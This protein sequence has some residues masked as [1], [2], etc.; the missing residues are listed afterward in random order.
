M[1]NQVIVGALFQEGTSQVRPPYFNGQHFSHWKVRMEIYAKAYDVKVWRVIKKGN[2]PLP[3]AAQPLAD[4]EDIDSYT[5]KQIEVV[6]VTNKA[7][8]LLYNAISGEEYEKISS[9]DTAKEMWDKLE[10]TY[11]GISKVKETHINMLVHDYELF[12]MK[13]GDSI[14]EM[15]ARFSKIIKDLKAFDKPYTRGDQVRKKFRSLPTTWK[16]KIVTLESQD[17]NKL[18]YDELRGE[19]IAF[20]NTHL[21]KTNQEE[22]KNTV[23]FKATTE[24]AENDLDDDLEALQ[25]EI[26][27]MSRN[28]DGLIRRFRNTRR[29]RIPPRQSRQ[30][31]EHDKNDGK[32]YEYGRFGHIQAEC[33]DLKRKIS[34]GFNK[35][36]SFGSWSDEN[37][38]EHEVIA[39]L[40]FMTI[41]ENEMNKSSGCWT[42][43][44]TSDDECK[45]NNENIFLDIL[46][47][48][49]KES[50]KLMNE[51]KRLNKE[52][53]DWNLKHEEHH[54]R[55]SK[56]KWYLD[57]ACSSHMTCDKNLFKEITK[58]DGGSI[59]FEDD[60]TGKIISIGTIPFNNNCDITEV[61]L[62]DGLNDNLLSINE[63]LKFFEIFCK[64]VEREKG[65]LIAT[66][67]S[68]H[69]GEFENRAF[70][71]F[72]D[73]NEGIKTRGALKKKANIALISQVEPKKIEE[74]LK[75]S[76]WIQ[77]MQEELDQFGKNQ[78][79]KLIP[80]PGNISVIG[81]K[82]VFKNKF[83]E[84]G[85]V[86]RNKARL[87]AQGY[88][89]QEG[90]DYDETFAPVARLESIRILMAYASFKG[91]MVF[92]MDIKSALLN[93]FIEEEVYMKQ[94]PGF[95]DS[96]FPYHVY[97][98]TKALYGLKQA[99]RA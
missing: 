94:P 58:I 96:K 1:E 81:T 52:V 44:D 95:V 89:Q 26:A 69:G 24:I 33:P 51:L 63:A 99:P 17:L 19:L 76:S 90:V 46:D 75:D 68:D 13:E 21:K 53:K 48:T 59:K 40:F 62:V 97:K 35:N 64:K 56:G 92:Q 80:K 27:M 85:K 55:S 98:L 31:N 47:L 34:R 88:S 25:E 30:I 39:N 14:E 18:S 6:Q 83:N 77:A 29:G 87:V 50:Q 82:W 84:D 86:A 11:E 36:K 5:N 2:Y 32:C 38:S 67:Q 79:W 49:L 72:W 7:R 23:A 65:Y 28:M 8:N 20:E 22:K 16:T 4:P 73:P 57:S 71:D 12:Q 42:D 10:I 61:Y 66:I 91:F 9:C 74:A 37:S 15:F 45:D 3:A 60:S 41:L 70:E 78:V 43:K 93:G 54:K